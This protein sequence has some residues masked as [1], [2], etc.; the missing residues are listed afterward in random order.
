MQ[1]TDEQ[2]AAIAMAT[3]PHPPPLCC[4]TGGPGTG[5][6]TTLRAL[7]DAAARA[8]Q[9]A[10]CAA[11]SGK[12]AQ[13]MTEAT[14]RSASTLHR[15]MGLLPGST[16]WQPIEADLLVIDEAS[17]IDVELAACTL[18]AAQAGGVQTV[19]LVGDADQL[20][21][22]GPGQPF[23]D[24]L[25]GGVC[26]SVR[27]TQVHRQ[28]QESGIVRA[29]HAI[30]SGGDVE[31][32]APDFRL[33]PVDDLTEIPGAIWALLVREGLDPDR[34]QILAPQRNTGGGV[35]QINRHVEE[36]RGGPDAPP[37]IREKFR[38]GTKVICTKNDYQ[39]E[40]FNG[41]IG[42]VRE[43]TDGGTKR[44]KDALVVEIAGGRKTYKGAGLKAL[45]P[46]WCLTVHKS[47]G[48]QWDDV[49]VVC[50]TG[51][52]YMLTRR[53]LYVAVTRGAKR[54]WLVGQREA[55]VKAARNTRDAK[56]DTWLGR[57]FKRDLAAAAELAAQKDLDR[58][59]DLGRGG[60]A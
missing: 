26:P 39:L 22:V 34:S 9:R 58:W 7:L 31:L 11:P 47:Q 13:R 54:V 3:G 30:N 32:D 2:Q 25:E 29:A 23:H 49:V 46:A 1:L 56:R 24:L 12:A 8:G 55:V 50:H 20:P 14:G 44:A 43:V 21:P 16:E 15:L 10:V 37:L 53:L 18:E 33:V 51:H 40:V 5:K 42:W 52:H 28:A 45:Q 60:A 57:R 41:E 35:E 59:D 48:S 6:T 38:P 36:Q 27:L 4:L 19:L 17:M